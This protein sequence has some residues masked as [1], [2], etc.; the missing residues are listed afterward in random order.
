MPRTNGSRN[1]DPCVPDGFAACPIDEAFAAIGRKWSLLVVRNLLRGDSHFNELLEHVPGINPKSLSQRL[2]E[3]E[4]E[5]LISK[6]ITA[7]SPVRIEYRLTAR[8]YA[9]VPILR[10]MARWS[11]EWAPEKVLGGRRSKAEIEACLE[12]WQKGL[13]APD[14][15]LMMEHG[16]DLVRVTL[17]PTAVTPPVTSKR[18]GARGAPSRV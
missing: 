7:Q 17:P 10:S 3:L 6:E 8:G 11:L 2:K 1:P 5:G 15:S 13:V 16:Q 14:V 12:A 9:I 18:A 4:K